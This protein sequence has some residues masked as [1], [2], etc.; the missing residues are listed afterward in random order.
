MHSFLKKKYV[1]H[2][3]KSQI[4]YYLLIILYKYSNSITFS[5][6]SLYPIYIESL[7]IGLNL[8]LNLYNLEVGMYILV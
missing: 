6:S 8:K 4:L 3:L 2:P 5:G 7:Y 1:V